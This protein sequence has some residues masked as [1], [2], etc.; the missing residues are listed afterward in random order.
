V[1]DRR[2][3]QPALAGLSCR[4]VGAKSGLILGH[5]GDGVEEQKVHY[6]LRLVAPSLRRNTAREDV[7]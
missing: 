5:L 4:T 6:V 2:H 7:C 1:P 3:L